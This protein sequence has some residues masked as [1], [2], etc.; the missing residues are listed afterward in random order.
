MGGGTAFGKRQDRCGVELASNAAD[1]PTDGIRDRAWQ[2]RINGALGVIPFDPSG[3]RRHRFNSLYWK[4]TNRCFIG[5]HHRIGAVQNGVGNITHLSA[6]GPR[7]RCHGIEHLGC[8]DDRNPK[9]VGLVDQIL[10]KKRN[11]FCRH[12]NPKVTTGHHHAIAKRQNRVDL[13]DRFE[14]LNF[15]HYRSGEAVLTNEF[16]DLLHV[17]GVAHEAERDPIHTLLKAKGEILP[18]FCGE[19]SHRKLHIREVHPL[20]VGEHTRNCH[21]A[22]EGLVNRIHP[23]N[24]HL[25][26]AVVKKDA[27][28]GRDFFGQLVVGD[29]CNRLV[30]THLFSRQCELITFRKRYRAF[31]EPA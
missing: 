14:L 25:N 13:I 17:R 18:I 10:L 15:C 3:D 31:F 26:A 1:C 29:C 8:R 22:M 20:V 5:Q 6:G 21:R 30:A 11:F 4:I 23:F 24:F 28:A 12:F 19:R 9:A 27:T 16:S 7:A 2:M